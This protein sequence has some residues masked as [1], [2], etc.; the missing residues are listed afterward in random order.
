MRSH[1]IPHVARFCPYDL[2]GVRFWLDDRQRNRR[3]LGPRVHFGTYLV[4]WWTCQRVHGTRNQHAHRLV[5]A[6][7]ERNYPTSRQLEPAPPT[8]RA[9]WP[10]GRCSLYGRKASYRNHR[11]TDGVQAGDR[12]NGNA[13]APQHYNELSKLAAAVPRRALRSPKCWH[14]QTKRPITS[15]PKSNSSAYLAASQRRLIYGYR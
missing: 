13:A 11:R 10:T 7:D 14:R 9:C 8:H 6:C 12:R 2:L 5:T 3:T 4:L 1:L 15:S